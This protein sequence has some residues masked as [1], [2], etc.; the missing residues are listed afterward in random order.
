MKK[1]TK[2]KLSSL[3]IGILIFF[4]PLIAFYL[5]I[6][7]YVREAL[8]FSIISITNPFGLILS[9]IL[10]FELL[11]TNNPIIFISALVL[12]IVTGILVPSITIYKLKKS[13]RKILIRYTIIHTIASL[14]IA[15]LLSFYN[16]YRSTSVISL[17]KNPIGDNMP[18]I[19]FL[20]TLIICSIILSL[21]FI[22][23]SKNK[24]KN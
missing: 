6:N 1:E 7:N 15:P 12:I 13:S 14:I 9:M 19:T 11:F 21:V 20:T 17:N 5:P 4:L 18:L 8:L 2:S 3:L 10:F 23:F 22:Y 16:S 24:I